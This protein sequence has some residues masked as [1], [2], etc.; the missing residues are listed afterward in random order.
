MS[1]IPLG[2]RGE[3]RALVTGDLAIDF[4]GIEEARVLATPHLIGL[5][6]MTARNSVKPLLEDGHDTVGTVVN[7]CHLA[8]TPMGM[9][10]TFISEV[11]EADDRRILFRVEASDE[12]ERIAE[13]THERYIIQVGRFAA[14][15]QAKAQQRG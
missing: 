10:V 9:S 4:L 5:L 15:V 1:R 12:R 7:V 11:I 14:R 6:E 13:G 8:A 3:H 2:T